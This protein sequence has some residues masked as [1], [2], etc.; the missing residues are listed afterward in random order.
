MLLEFLLKPC[1]MTLVGK[2]DDDNELMIETITKTKTVNCEARRFLSD[3]M[4]EDFL[5]FWG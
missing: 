1:N 5:V 4:S 3:L 2:D